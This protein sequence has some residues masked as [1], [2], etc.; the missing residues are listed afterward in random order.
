[1]AMGMDRVCWEES[2]IAV[3]HLFVSLPSYIR[4]ISLSVCQLYYTLDT[5]AVHQINATWVHKFVE[6]TYTERELIGHS[7]QAQTTTPN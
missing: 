6:M 4:T 5:I 3:G 7:G 2:K 1:M